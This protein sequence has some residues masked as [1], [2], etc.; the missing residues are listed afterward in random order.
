MDLSIF[1]IG[2]IID[3]EAANTDEKRNRAALTVK[4]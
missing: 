2:A 4:A 1:R 3:R